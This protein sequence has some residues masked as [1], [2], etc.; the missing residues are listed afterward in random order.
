M[1]SA[2]VKE[3]LK[4]FRDNI[5]LTGKLSKFEYTNEAIIKEF[6]ESDEQTRIMKYDL[7][8]NVLTFEA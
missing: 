2:I 8:N 5:N 4:M 6:S 3:I 1:K 7:E